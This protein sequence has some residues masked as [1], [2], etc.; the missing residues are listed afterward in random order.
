MQS[1]PTGPTLRGSAVP[2]TGRHSLQSSDGAAPVPQGAAS[3]TSSFAPNASVAATSTP[4]L[5][6]SALLRSRAGTVSVEAA[7]EGDTLIWRAAG[8]REVGRVR[9]RALAPVTAVASSGAA[10]LRVAPDALHAARD[11]G[12]L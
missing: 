10:L 8:A 4:L 9:L 7:L 2:P 1:Q 12:G 5:R 6:V 3:A 11:L